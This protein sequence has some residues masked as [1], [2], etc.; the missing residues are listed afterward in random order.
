MVLDGGG[1][2]MGSLISL[3]H[4]DPM[5]FAVLLCVFVILILI[6]IAAAA[7]YMKLHPAANQPEKQ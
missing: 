2:I 6:G 1:A 3:L 5:P 7:L 4:G